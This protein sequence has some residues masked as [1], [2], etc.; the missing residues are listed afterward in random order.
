[1]RGKQA[2]WV[3]AAVVVVGVVAQSHGAN[4]GAGNGADERDTVGPRSAE[5]SRTPAAETTEPVTPAPPSTPPP[6]TAPPRPSVTPASSPTTAGA[7][8]HRPARGT[9]LAALATLPV[10]G[11]APMTGYDRDR[12]GTAWLDADRN[13]CDTRNDML[14]R[15]LA[16]RVVEAGTNGCVVLSGVLADPYTG[17]RVPFERGGGADVDIDHVVALGNAWV[18]GAFRWDIRKRAALANDPLEL[19][20]VDASANR[21]K[22]DG[23]AAT[24]LPSH[25][26]YR[27]AYVARQVVVKHKYGLWVTAPE[28]A[29]M[30]RVLTACPG[31][32]LTR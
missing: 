18:T 30:Q 15:D 9:A 6:S 11:R 31:Q 2:G 14:R 5:S 1:M 10:K 26:S 22:G 4:N 24:W 19:L 17:S 32:P 7:S 12:F 29:A 13:G 27:C 16:D 25:K 8:A 23:D 28:K 3:L 21:Q 20:A